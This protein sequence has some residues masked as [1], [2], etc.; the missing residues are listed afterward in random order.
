MTK[1]EFKK[2][3]QLIKDTREHWNK[4]ARIQREY[5]LSMPVDNTF[6]ER[7]ETAVVD[8]ID[9]EYNTV[10]W[11]IYETDFGKKHTKIYKSDTKEVIADL[12]TVDD[13]WDYIMSR[14]PS[15]LN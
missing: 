2:Y 7:L 1:E 8:L 10:S 6:A 5:G 14:I 13:L 12:K 9:D 11:W 15:Q 4:I 3:I